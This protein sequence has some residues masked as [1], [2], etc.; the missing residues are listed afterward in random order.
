MKQ[1]G[2]EHNNAKGELLPS[3]SSTN[4][5]LRFQLKQVFIGSIDGAVNSGVRIVVRAG[6]GRE[7]GKERGSRKV[8]KEPIK[9]LDSAKGTRDEHGAGREGW[10]G[11]RH[12]GRD[13]RRDKN[14]ERKIR[15]GR[16]K[17]NKRRTYT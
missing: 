4:K 14:K 16:T 15:K 17:V 13:G 7:R 5:S 12:D 11:T 6:W 1:Q 2:N 3:Q 8:V 9:G 10:G